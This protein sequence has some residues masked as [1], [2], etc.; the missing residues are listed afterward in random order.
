MRFLI[1]A[2]P[3]VGVVVVTLKTFGASAFYALSAMSFGWVLLYAIA[4]REK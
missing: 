4:G 3:I 1:F 2:I